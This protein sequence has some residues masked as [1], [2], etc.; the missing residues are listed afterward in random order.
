MAMNNANNNR[1]GRTEL[2]LDQVGSAREA[3]ENILRTAK[4][5]LPLINPFSKIAQGERL[6]QKEG[7]RF[8][9]LGRGG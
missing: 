2:E 9:E 7:G 5:S 1:K 8:S 4:V 3:T 6:Y